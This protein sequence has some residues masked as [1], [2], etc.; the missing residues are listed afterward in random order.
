MQAGTAVASDA[1][2]ESNLTDL[3]RLYWIGHQLRP[4]ATHF[5]NAFSFTF[6]TPICPNLFTQAFAT[7]VCEYEVL[8]SVFVEVAGEGQQQLLPE[9]PTQL[10]LVDLSE[11]PDPVAAAQRWQ[12]ERVQRPFT[13]TKCLYDT[14]LLKL[15]DDHFVWFLNQHH[16]ITD[17]TSFFLIA[18][19]V[20][21][22]YEA[23]GQSKLPLPASKP[24]FAR[25][26]ALLQRQQQGSRAEASRAFW[27]A[28]VAQKPE[29]LCFYGRSLHKSS[30]NNVRWTQNLGADKT[31]RLIAAAEA[32]DLGTVTSEFRQFCLTAALFFALLHQMT[33]Q[34]ELG[35]VTT[36]HNRA[37]QVNKQTVGVLMELVPL[38]VVI[39]PDETIPSLMQKVAAAMKPL[40]L[41]YRHG[42]SQAT[43]DLGL[44][45]MFTF[46]QRPSLTFAGQPVAH[47][48]IHHNTG[49]EAVALHVHHL[50]DDNSYQLYLDLHEDIFT[51]LQ[52]AHAQQ[53]LQALI[54]RMLSNPQEAISQSALPWP[55]DEAVLANGRSQPNFVPPATLSEGV[56][57]Q[58]WQ[59]ILNQAPIGI[60]D[61]FFALGGSS[62]QAM[63]FL[64]RFEEET[65]HYLPF[66]AL[67]S[68]RTIAELAQQIDRA[69][70]AQNVIQLQ[71]GD[72]TKRPIFLLPGA[73]GNTL[74]IQRLA[75]HLSPQQPVYTFEMPTLDSNQLPAAHV[76]AL[77]TYYLQAIQSVQPAGPYHLGGYSAGGILAYEVA[78]QLQA[79]GEIV[80]TL[81]VI[82]M[83]APNPAWAVWWQLCHFLARLMRLSATREEA[84]Y[85]FGRDCWSRATYFWVRGLRDWLG[86][87]GRRAQRFWQML[88]QQKWAS[89][90][91]K[92]ARRHP[93]RTSKP[94][95]VLRDMDP[96]SL[97]HPR[98]RALFHLYD[99]AARSYLPQPYDGSLLLLRCPLGYGRKE[100]R[101][102]YP[103]YGWEKL[104]SCVETQVIQANGHLA[105]M[106][107]PAVSQVGQQ[108]QRALK[109]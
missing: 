74:A 77:A 99:R 82:D 2:A 69:A 107:E 104:A 26:A 84:I 13:L 105:L 70:H 44:E 31:A 30:Q 54:S 102:P 50:A 101:S 76:P 32:V 11:E 40:L 91:R 8:R 61:D 19:T 41:H 89:L 81:A 33:R 27:Q 18:E 49:S 51:E 28:L 10:R 6:R 83:P 39:T 85:L 103:D 38:L 64:S 53:S 88:R 75:D 29:P 20:L 46:V 15:A 71:Q 42:A 23:L 35:F 96:S 100:I 7:A 90:R 22:H 79:Q 36:I 65:G 80:A 109:K 52:I 63:A 5:N 14:A 106:Q 4:S 72:P 24:T 59:D 73:A 45:A 60:H 86:R 78:Q 67:L 94:N 95:A 92:L 16:L 47:E 21:T 48:I 55:T 97:A 1:I 56:L 37:T 25:Y 87:Y 57:Q 66:S 93:A 3:Q 34:T 98:A 108:I 12:A 17:A 62:W 43:V 58:I 68:G 9:P